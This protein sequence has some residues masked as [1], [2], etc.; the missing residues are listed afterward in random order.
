M[1]RRRLVRTEWLPYHITARVNNKEAFPLPLTEQWRVLSNECVLLRVLFEIELHSVVMMP[2]HIH[3]ILT[4][5]S[6]EYDLGR[7]MCMFMSQ[8][9]KQTN[10]RTGKSG[11]LFGGS[12]HRSA[13]QNSRYYYHAFKYLYR[14]PVR[15]GLCERVEDYKFS[16]FAGL[17]GEMDLTVPLHFTRSGLE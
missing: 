5:P 11:H 10:L 14:N 17:C 4:T 8:F 6:P 3:M 1:A 16:T 2:N 15:A 12:Y 9:T 7:A 13:I